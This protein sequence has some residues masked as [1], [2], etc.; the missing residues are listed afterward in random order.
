M[1]AMLLAETLGKEL[2]RI[3]YVKF[4]LRNKCKDFFA[5]IIW[6]GL[7]SNFEHFKH[8]LRLASILQKFE[9]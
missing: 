1:R 4:F 6:Q 8:C 9:H 3:F 5:G 2:V 7:V